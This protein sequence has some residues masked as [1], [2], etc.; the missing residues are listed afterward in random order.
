MLHHN[1][2]ERVTSKVTPLQLLIISA[3]IVLSCA[4]LLGL[5]LEHSLPKLGKKTPRQQWDALTEL[6]QIEYMTHIVQSQA[7]TLPENWHPKVVSLGIHTMDLALEDAE[8]LREA[9]EFAVAY[10]IGLSGH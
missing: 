7:P 10:P 1:I 5:L 9:A 6:E 8:T 2:N 3:V 4:I